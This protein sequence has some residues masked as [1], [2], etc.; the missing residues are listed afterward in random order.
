ML[1]LS[2]PLRLKPGLQP[3]HAR[4]NAHFKKDVALWR[5]SP[6]QEITPSLE[7]D[8]KNGG[9]NWATTKRYIFSSR[10]N[11]CAFVLILGNLST[12]FII[13]FIF[14]NPDQSIPGHKSLGNVANAS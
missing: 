13:F 5:H 9:T 3:T 1:R 4:H 12:V 6:Q 10:S 11:R 14:F 8:K 7:D 2:S